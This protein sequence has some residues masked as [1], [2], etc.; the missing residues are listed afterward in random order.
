MWRVDGADETLL[1]ENFFSSRTIYSQDM[2]V[3]PLVGTLQQ[4]PEGQ[5]GW[6]RLDLSAGAIVVSDDANPSLEFGRGSGFN[7]FAVHDLGQTLRGGVAIAQADIRPP[8]GWLGGS[9]SVY[10]RLGGDAHLMGNLRENDAYYLSNIAV[11]FGFKQLGEG[12]SGVLYTNSTIV[13]YRGDCAGGGAMEPAAS[14][15]AV[16]ST[17]WYRFVSKIEIAE[18]RYDLAVYDMGEE[19]PTLTTKTP[20][21]PVATFTALPFR[22]T[23]SD[24][25]G[26]SCIS[27]SSVYNPYSAYDADLTSRIDNLRVKTLS[28]LVLSIK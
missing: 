13:A 8:K 19:Q 17:H 2:R 26:V 9:G 20:A 28:G 7:D 25:G 18:S 23:A 10:V 1:Y 21:A 15:Y 14:G 6:T 12:V 24:L 3:A 22:R 11:G 16:D 5:D 4:N 27:V